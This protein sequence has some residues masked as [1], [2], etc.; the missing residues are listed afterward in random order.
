MLVNVSREGSEE[1]SM[2]NERKLLL[3]GL[4]RQTEMHGYI[5]NAH[6]E[7]ASPVTLKKPTAYNLL[8]RME[9]DG[10]IEHRGESTGER[11]RK[12][13][14]V[15][16][17]GEEAFFRLLGEQLGTY[18]SPESP[19]LVSVS[20]LDALPVSCAVELLRKRQDSILEYR[21]SLE[22]NDGEHQG[23]PHT[24][25][26]NLAMEYARRLADLEIAFLGEIIDGMD[27]G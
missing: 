22:S 20:F 13:F 26:T 18:I 15:T 10:W 1:V 21:Q 11:Q 23:D 19:G 25:S 7:G 16:G 17:K 12:V 9:M 14:S 3:L 4:L 6:L 8:D 2:T 27:C 5:L 24:G